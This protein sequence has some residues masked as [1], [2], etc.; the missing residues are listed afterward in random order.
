[1]CTAGINQTKYPKTK[2][3]RGVNSLS[4]LK[5]NSKLQIWENRLIGS[6]LR[7]V[8]MKTKVNTLLIIFYDE[9]A[10]TVIASMNMLFVVNVNFWIHVYRFVEILSNDRTFLM[11]MV[12]SKLLVL[13]LNGWCWQS[14]S[15]M[16]M[17]SGSHILIWC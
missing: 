11:Y 1:M 3:T 5:N 13:L 17:V 14:R 4:E 8:W 16:N 2:E 12:I 15:E 6:I 7:A 9:N 10:M